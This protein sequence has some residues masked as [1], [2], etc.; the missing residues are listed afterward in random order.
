[1]LLNKKFSCTT[2]YEEINKLK[3]IYILKKG[4][5]YFP[6]CLTQV[7]YLNDLGIDLEIF[8][9]NNS[10]YI[11]FLLD[12]RNIIHHTLK[13]DRQ[14]KNR[15]DQVFNFF[16]I[17]QEIKAVQKQLP[18]DCILW[19]GNLETAMTMDKKLL[20][21]QRFILNVLELYN[22]KTIYDRWLKKMATKA[23]LLI[24]CEK[25][26]AAIMKSRYSLKNTPIVIPN[27]PYDLEE[28][29]P[30]NLPID[31]IMNKL[32]KKFLIVY[33][34]IVMPDRPLGNIV[35][36]LKKINDSQMA[37]IV[38][39]RCDDRNYEKSLKAIYKPVYYLGYI[40]APQHLVITKLCHLG[41]ANYDFSSL[42][43]VFCAP[44]KIYE[45]A[46]FGKPMLASQNIGL[47]E[48]VG[49]CGAAECI[50]FTNIDDISGAIMS[51]REHY[52]KYSEASFNF[53]SNTDCKKIIEKVLEII[54]YKL[55]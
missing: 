49:A 22:E 12:Q 16:S 8:H 53:Y 19:I 13:K 30:S 21:S 27:K 7:L 32:Q 24:C 31:N 51:I 10:D 9:G 23:T 26:R 50:D 36:A 40:P 44:N 15:I 11:N 48:T 42:N 4:F 38:M 1:M 45:Y 18:N 39:G 46:K 34:G 6:P 5:Q 47:T 25:H 43:N 2:L 28:I 54:S 52:E 55:F 3:V 33:Q 29:F 17:S 37:F 20:S 14:S 35:K 41:I